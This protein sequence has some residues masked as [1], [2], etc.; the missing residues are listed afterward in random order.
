MFL[1]CFFKVLHEQPTCEIAWGISNPPENRKFSIHD[2]NFVV[3]DDKLG[4]I[5]TLSGF[6]KC[7]S[8]THLRLKQ[9]G[10]NPAYS[11]FVVFLLMKMSEFEWF[12]LL[13]NILL[14]LIEI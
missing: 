8:I 9:D 7:L 14:G 11:D 5:T 3:T 4:V 13:N 10:G 12:F 1:F 2:A 6:I